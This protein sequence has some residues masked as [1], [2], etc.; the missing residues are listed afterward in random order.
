MQGKFMSRV[1]VTRKAEKMK[2]EYRKIKNIR[3]KNRNY[4]ADKKKEVRRHKASNES[5]TESK[6]RENKT[7]K[8][9]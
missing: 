7:G 4:T 3:K 5:D 6:S 2:E 1:E 9:K 8:Y